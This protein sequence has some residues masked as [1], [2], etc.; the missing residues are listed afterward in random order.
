M[1][2]SLTH[3]LPAAI[4]AQGARLPS[5]SWSPSTM[6][7][8]ASLTDRWGAWH[9]AAGPAR[10][11]GNS[12]SLKFVLEVVVPELAKRGFAVPVR[13]SC[14]AALAAGL[15]PLPIRNFKNAEGQGCS[16]AHVLNLVW[17]PILQHLESCVHEPAPEWTEQLALHHSC[18][19]AEMAGVVPEADEGMD[20]DQWAEHLRA[21]LFELLQV[22]VPKDLVMTVMSPVVPWH[23]H[24]T[25][26]NA[27]HLLR[28]GLC[29]KLV[30][31]ALAAQASRMILA[32]IAAVP[33]K[34]LSSD[35][36]A[37]TVRQ[38]L[39]AALCA[40]HCE[41]EPEEPARPT[42]KSRTQQSRDE[43]MTTKTKEVLYMLQNRLCSFMVALWCS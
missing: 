14:P 35:E 43:T 7:K 12:L 41:P 34:L 27:L 30:G 18:L 5:W 11:C 19:L 38:E 10:T 29:S 8:E 6:D 39:V 1:Y 36:L 2:A 3:L 37:L 22:D 24:A 31:T 15:E 9:E 40:K 4:F 26:A 13:R 28:S 33:V 25:P 16:F 23:V 32:E 21:K 42:K 17:A 20:I